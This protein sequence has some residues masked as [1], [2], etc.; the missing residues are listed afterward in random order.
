MTTSV[1]ELK[2]SSSEKIKN[3]TTTVLEHGQFAEI[4]FD[5]ELIPQD[6]T[7]ARFGIDG[8]IVATIDAG[9]KVFYII[10]TRND[11]NFETDY[12][13]IDDSYFFSQD[14]ERDTEGDAT[15]KH[16]K[17]VWRDQPMVFGR[18]YLQDRFDYPDTTSAD[19]FELIYGGDKLFVHNLQPTNET[20]LTIPEITAE[21]D[22]SNRSII[23]N[24]TKRGVDRLLFNAEYDSGIS[25]NTP[26]GI[27]KEHPV[28]GRFS[29]HVDGG[30]YIGGNGR[31]AIV[32]DGE[33]DTLHD[34]YE[35]L[36]KEFSEAQSRGEILRVTTILNRVMKFVQMVMPYDGDKTNQ[37]SAPYYGD[38][39]V[40][41]SEYVKNAA[42]VCRHQALLNAYIIDKLIQEGILFGSVGVQR[43]TVLDMGGSHAWAIF[44]YKDIKIIIDS[45]QSFVGTEKQADENGLWR[46]QLPTD[47]HKIV[48][49]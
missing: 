19:H 21:S 20:I 9:G 15:P 3:P 34:V 37:I 49:R 45:T 22:E 4:P 6:E 10:D 18:G 47:Q 32:V 25:E 41:L 39:L 38:K 13:V 8:P 2:L 17:G 42:G 26:Y 27:Y 30:V 14:A 33:S 11:D 29:P 43:N 5:D 7:S 40:G 46:Y 1:E 12:L 36:K 28:I 48:G 31:E 35:T 24:N 23:D 44:T 16:Y